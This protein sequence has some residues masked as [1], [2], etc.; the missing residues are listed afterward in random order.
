VVFRRGVSRR[1]GADAFGRITD[2][3]FHP[4]KHP[5]GVVAAGSTGLVVDRYRHG[6][7]QRV[8]GQL[9]ALEQEAPQNPG[10]Q[11]HHDVV[12]GHPE[13]VLDPPESRMSSCV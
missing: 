8:V 11:S 2:L 6:G 7:H 3:G 9:A 13:P 4:T 5:C 12:D 10:A 1:D